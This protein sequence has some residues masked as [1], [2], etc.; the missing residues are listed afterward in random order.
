MN[1]ANREITTKVRKDGVIHYLNRKEKNG[2]AV[3]W[4][5]D[6]KPCTEAQY[7]AAYKL[8]HVSF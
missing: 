2:K 5:A 3:A 7:N 4:L 8:P 1:R 6:W